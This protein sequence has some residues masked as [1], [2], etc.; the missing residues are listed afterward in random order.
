MNGSG[1]DSDLH[2]LLIEQVADAVI[3]ADTSG[4]IR[5]WNA[6]AE[7]LFGFPAAEA[8]GQ[9]LDLIIPE[10][11]RGAHWQAFDAALACGA[12]KH[13][14]RATITR[15]QTRDGSTIYVDM[16]FSLLTAGD[17]EVLGSM[18]I[19]RDASE[20]RAEMKALR[21]RIAALEQTAPPAR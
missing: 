17:G 21:E 14:G 2:R 8:I 3:Y 20:R 18:A 1:N 15:A 5:L 9:S 13:G 10:R 7:R 11:L 12:T 16:S 4:V 6:A 19:A